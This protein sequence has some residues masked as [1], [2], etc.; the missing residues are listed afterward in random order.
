MAQP[1]VPIFR[2][3]DRYGAGTEWQFLPHGPN[4]PHK[5]PLQY[6]S[7]AEQTQCRIARPGTGEKPGR[8]GDRAISRIFGLRT[9]GSGRDFIHDGG[10]AIPKRAPSE[11]AP[12]PFLSC[13]PQGPGF[14]LIRQQGCQRFH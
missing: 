10:K 9:P 12:P 2:L 6:L 3:T 1:M 11:V 14:R 8:Q 7:K 4:K 5:H 13:S